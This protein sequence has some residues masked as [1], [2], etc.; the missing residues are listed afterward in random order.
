MIRNRLSLL[1]PEG[2]E[3]VRLGASPYGNDVEIFNPEGGNGVR[4]DTSRSDNVI[5]VYNKLATLVKSND[6]TTT[7][8]F[9]EAVG[10]VSNEA[11]NRVTVYDKGRR[12]IRPGDISYPRRK[13]V[14]LHQ[15]EHGGRVDVFNKQGENRAVMSVNEYGNGAVS[16]WDKNGYRR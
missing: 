1:N 8:V 15:T 16:T 5:R 12:V 14:R 6:G 4:L 9:S 10:L 11:E 13:A 7:R 3:G 2:R